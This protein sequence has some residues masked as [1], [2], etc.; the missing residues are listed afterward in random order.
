MYYYTIKIPRHLDGTI[1]K[2]SPGWFGVMVLS[3]KNV[4][5]LIFN[6]KEGWLLARCDDLF[7]PP[8]VK[9][10]TQTEAD[11]LMSVTQQ[12]SNVFVGVA[13]IA[14]RWAKLEADRL[15]EQVA[16]KK[17]LFDAAIEAVLNGV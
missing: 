6:D 1:A 10:I 8:E 12:A 16:E 15:A 13:K 3:P 7:I 2:Y 11:K 9:V 17:S 5:V 4:T 14:D